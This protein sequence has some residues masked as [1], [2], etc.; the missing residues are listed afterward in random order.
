[1]QMMGERRGRK[2]KLLLQAADGKARIA[3]AHEGSIDLEPRRIAEGFELFCCLFDFHGNRDMRPR[4]PSTLFRGFSKFFKRQPATG[5]SCRKP[6]ERRLE[7][8]SAA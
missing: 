1:M 2:P 6:A 4:R 3:G 5:A 8:Y 7:P